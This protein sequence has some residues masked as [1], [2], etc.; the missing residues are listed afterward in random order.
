[1]IA[2]TIEIQMMADMARLQ[3]DMN[4]ANTMVG[5]AM[6]NI[7][8]SVG[9][10]KAALAGLA[11]GLLAGFSL[12]GMVALAQRA[13][14]AAG[15]ID[16]LSQRVGISVKTLAEYELAVKLGGA[17]ME[18]FGKGMK[19][20]GANLLDHREALRK[21]GITATDLDGALR[22]VADV[23]AGMPDSMEKTNL[24]VKLFGKSGMDL[25]P[26]LNMGSKGLAD[27]AE[28]SA[29]YAAAM[30]AMAPTATVFADNMDEL[31]MHSK[32]AGMSLMNDLLPS[33]VLVSKAMADAAKNGGM[34]DAVVAGIQTLLT[35]DDL[36]KA[37]VAYVKGSE[38][39]A[40]AEGALAKARAANNVKEIAR[41]EN[42]VRLRKEEVA[43]HDN[44]RKMLEQERDGPAQPT[45]TDKS[46]VDPMAS[47]K[48]MMA[49]LGGSGDAEKAAKEMEKLIAAGKELANS[50]LQQDA[51]LSGDFLKKW[52]S[53]NLAYNHGAINLELLTKAQ[54]KLLEDQPLMKAAAAAE[55]KAVE[56]V[57][58]ARA[59]A[60]QK[61][62][63]G[64]A[65]YMQAQQEARSA[66]EKGA[67]EE[68][69][70]AQD[71]YDQYG[72]TKAQ[73]QQLA[74]EELKLKQARVIA[75][76]EEYESLQRQ[77]E[78]RE[79]MVTVI[80]NTEELDRQKEIWQS[81]EQ[82]AHTTFVNIFEGG[83][84]AF[85]KL[86]DT[87]KA[88]LL[89][90]LYQMTVKKWIFDI[91]ASVSGDSVAGGAF[92]GM[93]G[94][95]G[96]GIGGLINMGKSANTLY[97]YGTSAY[98]WLTGGAAASSTVGATL[99]G[100]AVGG[101]A[102]IGSGTV[103]GGGAATA[104]T[105]AAAT[106]GIG[107]TVMSGL[108]SM[109]PYGWIAAAA[110]AILS[111]RDATHVMSTGDATMGFDAQG[112]VTNRSSRD[113]PEETGFI[114]SL[115]DGMS[116]EQV[117]AANAA[118]AQ[119][120][121]QYFAGANANAAKYVETL[122]TGYLSAAKALGITT[123]ATN[124]TYGSNDSDGG[125]FRVGASAGSSMFDSGDIAQT[126]EALELA[127]SRAVLTALQGSE[128]P[129]WMQGVFDGVNAGA[130]DQAG[131]DAAIQKA[132]D[133]RQA[134]NTLQQI[135]G[136]DLTGISFETL[137]SIQSVAAEF[138]TVNT[139]FYQ[140]GYAMLDLSA[141]G[142]A[143]AAGIVNA[144][145]GLQAAQAQFAS[146]YQNFYS[147]A[148]QQSATYNA[149]QA[150][151]NKV[152]INYSVEQLMAANRGDIRAAVDSLAGGAGTTEGAA[153]YA[154]AV[155][156]ANTLATMKPALDGVTVAANQAA[157]AMGGGGGGGGV[158]AAG[159]ANDLAR[160][161]QSLTD[162]IF[163]EEQRVRD[164]MAG[165]G[166]EG[167]ARSQAQLAT[168]HAMARAGDK[169]AAAALPRLNQAMLM[170]AEA[171]ARS[172]DELNLIRGRAA[173]SLH[174]TGTM[175][176]GQY[177][178]SIPSFAIGTNMVPQDMLALIHAGEA[179]VPQAYNPAVGGGGMGG[180]TER[181][182]ALVEALTAE[183]ASL[184]EPTQK[185]AENTGTMKK[186]L[187]NVTQN[188]E[189]M[190]INEDSL[191]D[192]AALL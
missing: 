44:Y 160:A 123:V 95:G 54:A 180:N 89:D 16:D 190:L 4:R 74:V 113:F 19:G 154:A 13:I 18:A 188:G 189:G 9:T 71:I 131:I 179:I 46:G 115:V 106:G 170:L 91:S 30:E 171:N 86:R 174:T 127:A 191:T 57:A 121:E 52:D 81:I 165:G 192:L 82:T 56:D 66:S 116:Q 12:V 2:G 137:T 153:Q 136:T 43:V 108:A 101:S 105:G 94:G 83:Q 75:G 126:Q 45:A 11:G 104:T 69:K 175:L 167:L 163:K 61:E 172:L 124:F 22:Q 107:S 60:R 10:A 29:K 177:G 64:I 85:T 96:G 28:K 62:E 72:L 51:G 27:M 119:R 183:V 26:M 147:Q 21:A 125:K 178:L 187:V 70:A 58:A 132:V 50:L 151:L 145:G 150:D 98:N 7:E 140:F 110:I 159:A 109:G 102:G 173:N 118:S 185:T 49:A 162:A 65:A 42:T 24:A 133:L 181:L 67:R 1:M 164:Q 38:L 182:E 93:S 76:S 37:N 122:N 33:L 138:A 146:Y 176:A 112:N 158:G 15:A 139:A 103:L 184:K 79:K 48:A 87:L 20:L 97:D 68:L 53:L 5:G 128:L 169:D 14:D 73:I 111:M 88:T 144:M 134:Y 157:S 100:T 41:L 166:S 36:H 114:T 186:A 129:R 152:G 141:A 90:L 55:M 32:T 39:V 130:L 23:F 17:T 59:A 31:A 47:Y 84:D 6:A 149:V 78:L 168:A 25:I 99:G 120:M 148:E 80:A 63:E 155:K 156:A 161:F 40:A 142:G 8:R 117:D 35:G 135:P 34:L 143:A 92:P 77:I 3:A